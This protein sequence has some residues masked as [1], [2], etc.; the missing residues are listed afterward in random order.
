[1]KGVMGSFSL[2]T[3]VCMRASR[4]MKLVAAVSSSMMSVLH[5]SSSASWMLVACDV[6]PD[7]SGVRNDLVSC[8][9]R[10]EVHR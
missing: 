10:R 8:G 5:P 3:S 4:I 2:A 6:E 7:A 1:M 9:R